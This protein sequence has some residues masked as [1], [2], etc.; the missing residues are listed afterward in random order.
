MRFVSSS[1]PIILLILISII[2]S[3]SSC[4]EFTGSLFWGAY[5]SDS[6][7]GSVNLL[8]PIRNQHSPVFCAAC[9]SVGLSTLIHDRLSIR[10]GRWS[11]DYAPSAQQ[12]ISCSYNEDAGIRGCN[13]AED[14]KPSEWLS[15]PKNYLEHDSCSVYRAENWRCRAGEECPALYGDGTKIPARTNDEQGRSRRKKFGVDWNTYRRVGKWIPTEVDKFT[16]N[17]MKIIKNNTQ[18]I[19]KELQ[20]GPVLCKIL[21]NKKFVNVKDGTV[22]TDRELKKPCTHWTS[23]LGY[24]TINGTDIWRVRNS[25][26]EGWGAGGISNVQRGVGILGIESHCHVIEPIVIE[27][28]KKLTY[29]ELLQYQHRILTSTPLSPPFYIPCSWPSRVPEPIE[30]SLQA[31]TMPL[32]G[33]PDSFSWDNYHKQNFVS[34]VQN[35]NL[36][37]FCSACYAFSALGALQDRFSIMRFMQGERGFAARVVLSVQHILNLSVGS[38][39]YGGTPSAIY[40]HML[41]NPIPPSGCS[42]YRARSPSPAYPLTQYPESAWC[43]LCTRTS[44]SPQLNYPLYRV[45]KFGLIRGVSAMKKEIIANGPISCFVTKRLAQGYYTGGLLRD[46]GDESTTLSEGGVQVTLY[47]WKIVEGIQAWLIRGSFG[48]DWGDLGFGTVEMGKNVAGIESECIWAVGVIDRR[49]E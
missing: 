5:P 35:E 31:L 44:C 43:V 8:S 38:C 46:A 36:P 12:F 22:Y 42:A 28:S 2:L 10:M 29:Y 27:Q 37:R 4:A 20:K 48:A 9:W 3:R 49:G 17:D 7:F 45:S 14:D 18:E 15:D 26:G 30:I 32:T 23:I 21:V 41:K 11:G 16:E 40:T 24:D 1:S 33:I 47:G 6:P 19:I 25:W 13:K 39:K 34:Q